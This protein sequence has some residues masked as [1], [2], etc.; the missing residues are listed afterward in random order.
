MAIASVDEVHCVGGGEACRSGLIA[1]VA[2]LRS[3]SCLEQQE[4]L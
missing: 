4:E 1:D 2:L 3:A